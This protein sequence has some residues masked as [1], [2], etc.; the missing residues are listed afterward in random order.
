M[1]RKRKRSGIAA[2]FFAVLG[3]ALW[4]FGAQ[5]QETFPPPPIRPAIDENGVELFSGDLPLVTTDVV[6]GQSGA[7]GLSFGHL[8]KEAYYWTHSLYG[9]VDTVYDSY[10]AKYTA[11]VFFGT[12]AESFEKPNSPPSSPW[13]SVQGR[14]S[15]LTE[16]STTWTYRAADGAVIVYG[17]YLP[18]TSNSHWPHVQSVTLP[19]GEI[20]TFNYVTAT[21][22][23]DASCSLTQPAARLQS[24][25]N[26]RGYQIKLIYAVSD[27]N[28]TIPF[29]S[30]GWGSLTGAM[31]INMAVDW[32]DPLVNGCSGTTQA[33]P[34]VSYNVSAA[35]RVVTDAL[36]G[37][38]SYTQ[39]APAAPLSVRWPGSQTDNVIYTFS[40]WPRRVLSVNRN[41]RSWSYSYNWTQTE[42][43][44]VVTDP[45]NR[46]S[47]YVFD[48]TTRSIKSYTN[49]ADEVTTYQNDEKGR[50]LVVTLPTLETIQYQYDARGNVTETRRTSYPPGSDVVSRAGYDASCSAST[51]KKCNKPN[52]TQDAAGNQTDYV[53]ST[54]HGNPTTVTLPAP[55]P[56]AIRPVTTYTYTA[57]KAYYKNSS[58]AIAGAATNVYYLTRVAQCR[59]GSACSASSPDQL[60]TDIGYGA[61]NVANNRLPVQTTVRNGSGSLIATTS[62]SYD[63]VGNLV[64]TDGPLTGTVDKVVTRYDALRRVIGTVGPD[65]DGTGPRLHIGVR[66]TYNAR[67]LPEVV[68]TGNLP[69]QLDSSWASFS[70][71]EALVRE[72]DAD[73]R[74]TKT[75]LVA[76]G[77]TYA[78][79]QASFDPLGRIDCTVTRMN[80]AYFGALPSACSATAD[81]AFGP[82]RIMKYGYDDADRVTAVIS[83][84]GQPGTITEQLMTYFAGGRLETLTDGEGHKTTYSYDPHGRLYRVYYPDPTNVGASSSTDFEEFGYDATSQVVSTRTRSGHSIGTARDALGRITLRDLP[85]ST[86]EDVHYSY[87]NQ[88]RLLAALYD[89][90]AG[91]GITQTYDGL[92]RLAT[93]SV[94]GR[95]LSYQYDLAGRRTQLTHP[96]GFFVTYAYTNADE[97]QSITDSAGTVLATFGYDHLG[98]R[99]SLSRPNGA[100][101]SY[102][103]DAISR[104]QQLTQ[105]LSGT[106][107][108]LTASF[109]YNPAGQISNKTLSNDAAYTWTPGTSSSTVTAQF[110][111]QNQLKKFA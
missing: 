1:L 43:T 106:S 71:A 96:D 102:V 9:R 65:P 107:F 29:P 97:L 24:V 110:D 100:A 103:P 66:T 7:G 26:N 108:D 89:N 94:F 82:D 12:H 83:G 45:Q 36:G 95:Q 67:G 101:T 54:A 105:D 31:G 23:Q 111:G 16:Y 14:G 90:V 22:C 27:V 72:F 30:S 37:S 8:Y 28:T 19:D 15:T 20:R 18:G 53:Y 87:D 11:T 40:D 48:A 39:W 99:T 57:L 75:A 59:T 49:T 4:H 6:I 38:T 79:E 34:T 51:Q 55:T 73:G 32:C 17:K 76:G 62:L 47:T 69:G 33:W 52:W 13:V 46:Q 35:G 2:A 63:A 78:V 85:S 93:R 61:T 91:N 77:S 70:P 88:G 64:A 5:A 58:G 109:A 10:T 56:G 98:S 84:F 74:V 25:T 92:G 86:A 80:P 81:G 60:R 68:E 44:T 104:L 41:G 21:L 50:P 42:R 3:G